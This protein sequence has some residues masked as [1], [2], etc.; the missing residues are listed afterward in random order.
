[1]LT[2]F[3]I[4]L[5]GGVPQCGGPKLVAAQLPCL[6][7]RSPALVVRQV[8]IQLSPLQVQLRA[9]STSTAFA[10]G[11]IVLSAGVIS[12]SPRTQ[13]AAPAKGSSAR[14]RAGAVDGRARQRG[15]KQRD[16]RC[17]Q[18]V[19]A[20]KQEQRVTGRVQRVAVARRRRGP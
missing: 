16:R 3:S 2:L 15:L 6:H 4:V 10:R 11:T 14:G 19:D 1:M 12:T 20:A 8:G 5:V 9:R 18:V 7:H 13:R 17:A